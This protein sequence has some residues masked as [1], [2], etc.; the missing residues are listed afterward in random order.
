MVPWFST[1]L[2]SSVLIFRHHCPFRDNNNSEHQTLERGCGALEVH[3]KYSTRA[4]SRSLPDRSTE[5]VCVEGPKTTLLLSLDPS[6]FRTD[7]CSASS[8][9]LSPRRPTPVIALRLELC[10][11]PDPATPTEQTWTSTSVALTPDLFS[12]TS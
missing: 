10:V 12:H 2:T 1:S 4:H 8:T 9:F 3:R 6:P 5:G 11:R 7:P